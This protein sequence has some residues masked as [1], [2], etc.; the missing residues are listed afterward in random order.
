MQSI[1][2]DVASEAAAKASIRIAAG[3]ICRAAVQLC[4][5]LSWPPSA[6]MTHED[7]RK[8]DNRHGIERVECD[9]LQVPTLWGRA[10]RAD[11]LYSINDQIMLCCRAV[12]PYP[13]IACDI[14]HWSHGQASPITCWDSTSC[15]AL[16]SGELIRIT[17][18]LHPLRLSVAMQNQ[19]T[20]RQGYFNSSRNAES[21]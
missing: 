18:Q 10:E 13:G 11:N 6:P 19:P 1:S 16:L 20:T 21:D 7:F 15:Y 2:Q 3:T 4:L 12:R 9:T 5:L 14:Q 17:H 8:D